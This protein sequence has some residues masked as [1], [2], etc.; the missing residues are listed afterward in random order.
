MQYFAGKNG[1]LIIPKK[2]DNGQI[3]ESGIQ[4]NELKLDRWNFNKVN[5]N[6]DI[7]NTG[8]YGAEQYIK[9]LDAGKIEGS[10][11]MTDQLLESLKDKNI[12]P[13]DYVRFDLYFNYNAT[14]PLG[15]YGEN[16]GI[17]AIIDNFI[18]SDEYGDAS[19]FTISATL[20]T[21]PS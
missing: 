14:P 5:V 8:A 11:F 20:S 21:V 12:E 6:V 7:S 9:N 4:Y 1:F 2:D 15:F 3:V 10:G 13:G 17:W 19:R 18:Y 16:G